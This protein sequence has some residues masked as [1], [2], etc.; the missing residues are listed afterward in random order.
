MD[1]LSH[2]QIKLTGEMSTMQSIQISRTKATIRC[3]LESF[4]TVTMLEKEYLAK[5][6][7]LIVVH[8]ISISRK[9][10]TTYPSKISVYFHSTVSLP[11]LRLS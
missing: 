1:K 2:K 10:K 9:G 3:I 6:R 4:G 5:Q 11:S 8:L 7:T